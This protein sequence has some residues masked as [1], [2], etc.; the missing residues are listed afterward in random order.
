MGTIF[1][2]IKKAAAKKS[3][4]LAVLIDPEN[5][6]IG[7]A[8]SFFKALPPGVTHIFVGGSTAGS[9]E[10]RDA[11]EAI[12]LNSSLPVII[13]PGD[14]TQITSL[15]DGLLFLS[16]ISGRNPEYLIEQQVKAV[17]RLRE[18]SLEIIPTGYILIDGGKDC[19]VQRVSHTQPIARE[20][21]DY[22]VETALAGEYSGKKLIYLEAGSGAKIPVSAQI[23]AAVRKAL[24]IPLIVGGGI[25]N[26]EQLEE[27][28]NAGA[29]LVVIGTAFE[30]GNYNF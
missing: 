28:Y 5:F 9:A 27:A 6:I 22:I 8:T 23:I 3:K 24:S 21:I 4:F 17:R 12:K 25:R 30:N 20:E 26:R 15:A 29:D 14:H 10:T 1:K 11:V 18:S 2:E 13:F 19:T 7:D 16:L